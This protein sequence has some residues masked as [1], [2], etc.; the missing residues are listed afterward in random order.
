MEFQHVKPGKRG[1]FVRT[2]LKRVH[3]GAVI[4]RTFRAGEKF[5]PVRT[6]TCKMQFL[7]ADGSAAHF[8]DLETYD[9]I[10]IPEDQAQVAEVGPAEP[11]GG[12]PVR[13]RAAGGRAG[14]ERGGPRGL[15]DRAGREG[16]T[17]SGGGDKETIRVPDGRTLGYAEVGDPA[18]APLVYFHG[19]PG[20]RLDFTSERYDRA[21][22][23]AG[24]RFIGTDRPGFGLSDPKPGRG[25]ADWAADVGALADSLGLDRFAVLGYSRGGRYALACA[26][27][28]PE[29][30]TAVGC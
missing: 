30:L 4:D 21:L 16:D 9:Q 6:E 1:A 14:A 29:R 26:A 8:M 10:T 12:G 19:N 24:V 23:A 5:R 15:G 2:K 17:A 13:R 11:G 20:S 22:R 7:Y 25:Y 28:I 27:R 18:G 3:D